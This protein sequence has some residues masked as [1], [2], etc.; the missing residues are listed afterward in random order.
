VKGIPLKIL[1]FRLSISF[2]VS[3]R[4]QISRPTQS[5]MFYFSPSRLRSAS[6]K[7]AVTNSVA[8]EPES[9]S[10][11]LL[12]LATDPYPK[13]VESNPHPQPISLRSI[14]IPSSHLHL[15]LP[16]GWLSHQYPVLYPVLSHARHLSR[17]ISLLDLIFLM[18]FGDG[19]KL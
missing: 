12:Q 5:R 8:P 14:L 18:M 4:Y 15:G 16:R 3:K 10:P 2:I 13:P 17:L 1:I 9:S 7:F 11:H 19:Y 6:Y